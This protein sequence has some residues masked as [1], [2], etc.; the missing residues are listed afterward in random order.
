MTL[1]EKLVRGIAWLA[2]PAICLAATQYPYFAPGGALSCTGQCLTQSVD[3][4]SGAFL[5]NTLPNAKLTNSSVTLNGSALA[6][7]GTR[8]LSL[9]SS[10]FVNQGTTTT[11]LHGNAAG[12]PSFGAV[13][14]ATEVTS[15]LAVG[16]GGTG[17]TSG[18]LNGVPYFSATNTIATST[19]HTWNASTNTLTLG[20]G[21]TDPLIT[22][23][24]T[25]GNI[26]VY[27]KGANPDL[28]SFSSNPNAVFLSSG[29][30]FL[31]VSGNHDFDFWSPANDFIALVVKNTVA[32][33]A[34]SG[35]IQACNENFTCI[36]YMTTSASYDGL[37]YG[38]YPAGETSLMDCAISCFFGAGGATG[39]YVD[40]NKNVVTHLLGS[41]PAITDT[42]GF[43]YIPKVAGIPTGVPA[44]LTGNYAQSLPERYDSTNNR[45]CIYNS[46]WQCI[47]AGKL[48]LSGT[49]GSIGGGALLAGA[50]TSGTVAVTGSTTAM[51]VVAT[52]VTYPGDGT[53]W[54]GYVSSAG[55]VTVKVCALV[56]VTP[57][58]G[59]YNVRV[60]Q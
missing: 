55:T 49:T 1:T 10:D 54:K 3:L 30:D 13:N 56:A 60:I 16:N 20:S 31:A 46:G 43:L 32:G 28:S 33:N 23:G 48:T 14:L 41:T 37:T 35:G 27:G 45:D 39:V 50:C 36:L 53:D 58:A 15:T 7:G 22:S 12:N 5:L 52:P 57:T 4:N 59:N 21:A 9:A 51:S 29:N 19:A 18:T 38:D 34:A 6:L 47:Q 40:P 26:K 8:T 17:L 2:L 11:L 25:N 24:S 42:N 44:N